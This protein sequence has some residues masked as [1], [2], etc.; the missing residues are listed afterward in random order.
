[1]LI[2]RSLK[3]FMCGSPYANASESHSLHAAACFPPEIND[4]L[5][6]ALNTEHSTCVRHWP[7]TTRTPS[8]LLSALLFTTIT[9]QFKTAHRK[10]NICIVTV[11]GKIVSQENKKKKEQSFFENFELDLFRSM[12]K[13]SCIY[14]DVLSI[15]HTLLSFALAPL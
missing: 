14:I 7:R 4:Q 10:I 6:S 8:V 3:C 11:V 1:M 9:W 15:K 12:L 13:L 2:L 5:Y